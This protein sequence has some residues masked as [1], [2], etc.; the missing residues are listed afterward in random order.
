MKFAKLIK[1]IIYF[2]FI[3]NSLFVNSIAENLNRIVINGNERIT[4]E[5]ILTFLPVK[6]NDYIDDEKTNSVIKELYG[7][8]F[9][10][11]VTVNFKDNI[12]KID[13]IENP[14]IQNIT[15]N[16]IKSDELYK[17]I[18]NGLLLLERSSLVENFVESD[19]RNILKNLQNRGYFFSE[20]KTK[21]EYLENNRVNLV[22]D[23]NLGK[24]SKIAK[25]SFLGN[26]VF[27]DKELKSIIL[28]EEYRF[29]KFIS[30]KKYLNN[31]LVNFDKRLLENFYKNNGYYDV[32][33]SSS[34]AKLINNDEFELI[35]NIDAGK[36]IYFG[37]LNIDLPL[38]YDEEN[39][40][41]LNKTLTKLE[42]KPYSI[43]SIAKITEEIDLLAL[44]E[45]YETIDIDVI[46]NLDDNNLNLSFIIKESEKSIIK[47]INILGNNVTRENVIRNQFEIDE[48]DFYNKILMNKTINNLKS[49]D[50]FK[51]VNETITNDSNN[52]KII[53]IN[54]EEKATGELGASAGVGTS[55]STI[56]FFINENNYL[57]RG[58]KLS[59][60]F[61]LSEESI[62]GSLSIT[63]PNFNDTD[64]SFYSLIEIIETDRLKDFGYKTN[65]NGFAYGT[66]FEFLDDLNLGIGNSFYIEKIETDST[67]SALQKKQ[68]GNYLDSFINLNFDYDKRNQKFKTS[69]G[70]RS[71][72][73]IDLPILS[74]TNTLTNL[75][76]YTYYTELYKD[77][78][79]SLSFFG[80]SSHSLTGDDIKLTERNFISS[81]RLRGF[82][83]GKIG[84]KD[85]ND[86][87]GGNYASSVNIN[88]TLP[89]ILTENQNMDIVLFFD[90][91]NVW[92]VDYSS[93]IT[94]SNSI[95]S[96][97][98][99]AL[100]WFSP[101]GP[102]NFSV[103]L[104]ITKE[105]T[106]KTET[107]RF[108][109][110]TTF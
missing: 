25:I 15:Y 21:I 43:N 11:N 71:F 107:F 8:N 110:G 55:G 102:L 45:Q 17:S 41:K 66:N 18:T 2:L 85:G 108:N 96:S 35:F 13:L 90:A 81:N 101:L 104:P 6:I 77:N 100:D 34:F 26:K 20:I 24:K 84:P 10:K 109:I 23:I 99:L 27:K 60:K 47:K 73:G 28:S 64:K 89:Q 92:G 74:D 70:Y 54:V 46:E 12:L 38:N 91:A 93:S 65:K 1:L 52:E 4:D 49:L 67:A 39:F 32:K 33:I 79:T 88:S 9:F 68:E 105:S 61:S 62:K 7:T 50:F 82:E 5:T 36:L 97:T 76:S 53:E 14:I 63:N 48:G 86:Y 103:A 78:I 42:G 83:S 94:D 59:S 95:R 69:D 3:L 31:D 44:S 56:A 58:I 16:G 57:G 98:G 29:W 72:Y 87:I 40:L 80:K 75:F 106:D 37:K 30:G 51:N 19:R 22:Y